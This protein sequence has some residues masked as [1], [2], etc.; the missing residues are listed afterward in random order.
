MQVLVDC[1]GIQGL[2]T[3][4]IPQKL[5]ISPG[6][7]LSVPF[8]SRII[9]AIAI[10]LLNCP[11]VDI[12]QTRI[13]QVDTV[14]AACFF[15]KHYWTLLLKTADY[16]CTPLMSVIRMALPPGLLGKSQRRIRLIPEAIPPGADQLCRLSA[17]QVL[18]LLGQQKDGD[19]SWQYLNR[20]IKGATQG[21]H[22]LI[23]RGWVTSYLEPAKTARPKQQKAVILLAKKFC[24]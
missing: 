9:A 7:I 6:D 20:Q 17:Q 18:R 13:R 14:T 24:G 21:I 15:P 22:D 12:D 5:K 8:G 19:Y 16:Y 11:P 2:Y 3:Y 4:K 1:P 10:N 23:K